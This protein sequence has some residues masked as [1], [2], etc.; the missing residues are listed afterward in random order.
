MEKFSVSNSVSMSEDIRLLAVSMLKA[1]SK[2]RSTGKSG[3]NT[4]QGW[5]YATLEDII[6]A[7]EIALAENEILLT[8]FARPLA[9]G[10]QEYLFTRIIH[11]PSG[12]W[13]EDMRKLETEK[14]GNQA[15]GGATTYM[16]KYAIL[17]LCGIPTED[18]DG[19]S[20]HKHIEEKSGG[21]KSREYTMA[22]IITLLASASNRGLLEA[23]LKKF[24]GVSRIEDINPEKYP[25]VYN[26]INK[27]K[28]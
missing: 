20:E 27:N 3:K 5:K 10:N 26:Y 12:Q 21:F 4:G 14:P 9:E 25:M 2:F 16:R 15:K 23:N 7:V 17:S 24:N 6:D 22:D 8:H 1:K 18:D 13:I 28:A 11:A 19:E